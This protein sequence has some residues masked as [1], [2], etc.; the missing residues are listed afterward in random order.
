M[1]QALIDKYRNCCYSCKYRKSIKTYFGTRHYCKRY[2]AKT[3]Y[4][5]RHIK[6]IMINKCVFYKM[7][8]L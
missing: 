6:E 4:G 7:I 8:E 3:K 5:I 2:S 1:T